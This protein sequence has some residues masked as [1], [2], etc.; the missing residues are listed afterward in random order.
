MEDRRGGRWSA[1]ES[2]N[3]KETEKERGIRNKG[4]KE[5]GNC[6]GGDEEGERESGVERGKDKE[7]G[8]DKERGTEVEKERC[9]NL[10]NS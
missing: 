7:R 3:E 4:V 5:R 10:L 9:N 2:F 6:G 1:V 8:E